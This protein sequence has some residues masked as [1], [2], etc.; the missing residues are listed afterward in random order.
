MESRFFLVHFL[1][2][3]SVKSFNFISH[4]SY[5]YLEDLYS[6]RLDPFYF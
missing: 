4:Y 1:L 2:Y 6:R 5:V 3:S